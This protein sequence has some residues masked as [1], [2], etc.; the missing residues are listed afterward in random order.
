MHT[1]NEIF[2]DASPE[3]CLACA[4]DVERWPEILPHYRAVEFT[5]RDGKASVLVL[6]QAFRSFGPLPYPIWWESEMETSETER[7]VRYRHVRGITRGMDVVWQLRPEDDR[8]HVEII[9]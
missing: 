4:S 2:I 6:M 7:T 8:T 5:R 1:H 3:V 9:H